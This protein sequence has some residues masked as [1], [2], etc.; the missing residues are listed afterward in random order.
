M[1]Y[2]MNFS[3]NLC[4]LMWST[5]IIIVNRIYVFSPVF[6]G[7]QSKIKLHLFALF[8]DC[9]LNYLHD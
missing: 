5:K 1:P 6:N 8:S 2:E 4:N 7:G 3:I 9:A